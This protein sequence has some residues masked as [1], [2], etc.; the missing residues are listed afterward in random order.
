MR[1]RGEQGD[2]SDRTRQQHPL[3]KAMLDEIQIVL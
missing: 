2:Q 1:D 3:A